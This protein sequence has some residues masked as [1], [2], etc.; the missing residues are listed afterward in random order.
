VYQLGSQLPSG[1]AGA[2]V[3][4]DLEGRLGKLVGVANLAVARSS[5]RLLDADTAKS[6]R[7]LV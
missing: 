4:Q 6:G 7:R 3:A 5:L 2:L 1:Q